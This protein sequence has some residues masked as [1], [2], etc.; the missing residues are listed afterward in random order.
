MQNM[1]KPT[2]C[3]SGADMAPEQSSTYQNNTHVYAEY[4]PFQNWPLVFPFEQIFWLGN[5]MHEESCQSRF[6]GGFIE[7]EGILCAAIPMS[8]FMWGVISFIS[9]TN[10]QQHVIRL[11]TNTLSS[12]MSDFLFVPVQFNFILSKELHYDPD[13][14]KLQEVT[15]IFPDAPTVLQGCK[16]IETELKDG[17]FPMYCFHGKIMFFITLRGHNN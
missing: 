3:F 12:S 1:Q 2:L 17:K 10:T 15:S 8:L 6:N 9:H 16:N 11:T 7:M 5:Y 14:S 4:S 13:C